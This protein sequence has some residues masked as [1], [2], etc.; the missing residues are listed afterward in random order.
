[1]LR[2]PWARLAAPLAFVALLLGGDLAGG[3]SIRIGG[4][5][6]AVPALCAV[7]LGPRQVLFVTVVTF[8]CVIIA[9]EDNHQFDSANFPVVIGTVVLIGVGAVTAAS[10]RAR[11]ER[12]LAQARWVAT[13]AQQVLL[14]PLPAR[15]GTLSLASLYMAAEEEAAIGGDLYAATVLDSGEPRL[16]IGDVQGKGLGA[17]EV[18]GFLMT[19]FRRAARRRVKLADLPDYLDRRLREDLLDLAETAPPAPEGVRAAPRSGPRLLEGFVT[20]V[21]VDVDDG[22]R[23][24]RVANCGH[25]PPLLLHGGTV[26]RLVPEVPALPLGL[27]DIGEERHDVDTY[28]LDPGDVLLLY[29]DGVTEARDPDGAF[30]PLADRLGAWSADPPEA[31]LRHLRED[32]LLHAAGS[33][34]DDVAMVAV[35][36]PA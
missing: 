26:R 9:A 21:V 27:G 20:A 36:R 5:M 6:I 22:G 11:R 35:Q 17:V 25:P 31:L 32:L 2:S 12:Q 10:I 19:G 33:L 16:M 3:T 14:R 34:G 23:R 4:L 15:L 30:Y 24:L 18:A 13:V 7:F 28:A 29:T 8:G 1:M